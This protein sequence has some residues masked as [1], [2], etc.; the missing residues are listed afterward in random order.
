MKPRLSDETLV[1]LA[2]EMMK[3]AETDGMD[4]PFRLLCAFFVT[5][6][7]LGRSELEPQTDS[8]PDVAV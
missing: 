1:Y 6:Y 5:G 8:E 2:Q 4:D 7:E 3:V